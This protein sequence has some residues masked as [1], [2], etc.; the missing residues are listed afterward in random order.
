MVPSSALELP[1]HTLEFLMVAR[2]CLG[3]TLYRQEGPC[4][5]CHHFSDALGNH[6]MCYGSGGERIS[7][8]IHLRNHLHDT[9]VAPGCHL[10]AHRGGIF[11]WMVQDGSRRGEEVGGSS[12]PPIRAGGGRGGGASVGEVG[13]VAAARQ[14][15]NL[16]QLCAN[17]SCPSY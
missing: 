13:H 4:P 10:S 14:L 16:G 5:S 11:C 7:H 6:A 12:G 17:I 2:Y 9:A 1:M 3:L 8:H 15:C